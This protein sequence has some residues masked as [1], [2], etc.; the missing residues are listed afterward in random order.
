[1][2]ESIEWYIIFAAFVL[3]FVLGDPV[4]LPHPV[5]YMG[6]AISFFESP[7]RK[8]IKD[9]FFSG[10]VFALF[11]ICSTFLFSTVLISSC[12]SIHPILGQVISAIT[13]FYCFSSKS[14]EDAAIAVSNALIENDIHKARQKVAII[15]GRQTDHLDETAVTRAGIETVAENFVDGFLSPLFFAL[16][17]GVPAALAYK[18]INTLDSMVG[19]KNE[20]YT[21]FGRASAK[22]DDAANL[23][24]ARISVILISLASFCFSTKR[25][26]A[27]FKTG[28]SEGRSHKSPNAGFPEAGFAGALAIKLGGPNY[29]HGNLVEKPFIGKKFKDPEKKDIKRACD[30]MMLSSFLAVFVSSVILLILK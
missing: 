7:F 25:G 27:A 14:L 6:N 1:M 21:L 16:I 3:D 12:F 9:P 23:I 13:L 19:Y 17:G 29:Y 10:L 22:I 11:L 5:I 28:V 20:K 8:L 2:F 26:K 15:V 4:F 30:L 18:M 24:P